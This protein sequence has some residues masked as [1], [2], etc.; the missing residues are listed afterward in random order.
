MHKVMEPIHK[1][2][3]LWN[4][5]PKKLK[6]PNK[7][8]SETQ[9]LYLGEGSIFNPFKKNLIPPLSLIAYDRA[10]NFKNGSKIDPSPILTFPTHLHK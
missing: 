2:R 4:S 9:V 3:R 6:D 8:I 1:R 10:S 7:Y 5:W